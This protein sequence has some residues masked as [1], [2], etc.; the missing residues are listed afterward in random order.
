[1][2]DCKQ[3]RSGTTG[4]K[5]TALQNVQTKHGVSENRLSRLRARA[6]RTNFQPLAEKWLGA[7]CSG[8]QWVLAAVYPGSTFTSTND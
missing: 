6:W 7:G 3:K 5:G 8:G 2:P 1:L 4:A